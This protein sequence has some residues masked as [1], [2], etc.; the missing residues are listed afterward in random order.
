M[1]E[2]PKNP[3]AEREAL[4]EEASSLAK[5]AQE[6]EKRRQKMAGDL[7]LPA[8]SSWEDI[9][10]QLEKPI[11]I[12]QEP[13]EAVESSEAPQSPDE[14]KLEIPEGASNEQIVEALEREAEEWDKL[15]EGELGTTQDY[16]DIYNYADRLENRIKI[17]KNLVENSQNSSALEITKNLATY[18]NLIVDLDRKELFKDRFDYLQEQFGSDFNKEEFIKTFSNEFARLERLF[19]TNARIEAFVKP[20]LGDDE[21]KC[22][23]PIRAIIAALHSTETDIKRVM[24]GYGIEADKIKLLSK[25]PEGVGIDKE[26]PPRY[27]LVGNGDKLPMK[28]M[29][30][31]LNE[32]RGV[33]KKDL[34][35]KV[36]DR[37]GRMVPK[38]NP[39]VVDD[40]VK[41]GF[42]V[43]GVKRQESKVSESSDIIWKNEGRRNRKEWSTKNK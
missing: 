36:S 22:S 11:D 26:R 25:V 17:L 3:E 9:I 2:F 4:H 14:I 16:Q 39:K 33:T 12:P 24:K 34:E 15:P 18:E 30:D 19:V 35:E 41:I 10:A 7:E 43:D 27:L 21:S 5:K 31:I 1:S 40:I 8:E 23:L 29:F 32:A 42:R 28:D 6:I 37:F 20:L 13:E 38:D